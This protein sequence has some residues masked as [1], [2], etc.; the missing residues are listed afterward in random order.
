MAKSK[1]ETVG[2]GEPTASE[3]FQGNSLE[4]ELSNVLGDVDGPVSARRP[5]GL[6]S[7]GQR[8]VAMQNAVSLA[9]A[10]AGV[11]RGVL[12]GEQLEA[13]VCLQGLRLTV[14]MLQVIRIVEAHPELLNMR[15]KAASLLLTEKME[16]LLAAEREQAGDTSA[17]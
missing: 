11:D 13:A 4:Q 5:A 8:E 3:G 9:A 2:A 14:R 17:R 6:I 1:A 12:Q 16:E 7:S 15:T 10:V